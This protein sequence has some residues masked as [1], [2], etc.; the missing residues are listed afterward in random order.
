MTDETGVT[1]PRVVDYVS[2]LEALDQ[3]SVVTELNKDPVETI[4]LPPLP[5]GVILV[6]L[7]RT[8]MKKMLI[9]TG[10]LAPQKHLFVL[11]DDDAVTTHEI[12]LPHIVYRA[13][14]DP[15]A[16]TVQALSL[17]LCSP[18][19]SGEPDEQTELY[20]WPFSN[21]YETFGGVLEGVCWPHKH[22]LDVD[23][24]HIP[25]RIVREFIGMP[26]TT[27]YTR[28][29]VDNA[30][31]KTYREFLE[32]VESSGGLEHDWLDPCSMNIQELHD[33][34]RRDS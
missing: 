15:A 8:T 17:A 19:L 30:P 33:Q 10:I 34:R 4:A 28:D 32:L 2:L 22:K 27:A 24:R 9:L 12:P 29:L 5:D 14:H 26:N 3:S 11:G 7:Q 20:R 18:G 6:D 25:T 23:A 31:V 1:R 16:R 13:V 21:V